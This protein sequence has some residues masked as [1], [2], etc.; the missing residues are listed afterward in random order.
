MKYAK[1]EMRNDFMERYIIYEDKKYICSVCHELLAYNRE[2]HNIITHFC[3]FHRNEYKAMV[4]E[5][6]LMD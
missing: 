3:N 6:R 2:P 1:Y 4:K 5:K